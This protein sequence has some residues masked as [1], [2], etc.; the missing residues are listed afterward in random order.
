MGV[1]IAALKK[2]LE[3]LHVIAGTYETVLNESFNMVTLQFLPRKIQ[4]QHSYPDFSVSKPNVKLCKCFLKDYWLETSFA[5]AIM[6]TF[7]A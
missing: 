2:G 7:G 3:D 1:P 5:A 4:Q 6:Q